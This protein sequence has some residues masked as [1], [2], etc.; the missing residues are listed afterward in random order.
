M[1]FPF[2]SPGVPSYITYAMVGAVIGHEV[3][4][5]FDDQGS[6]YDEYGNLH[7]W[8]DAKT[9]HKFYEK[10]QCFIKQYSAVKVKEAGVHLNGR[11]SVGENIADNAGVKTALIAYKSWLEK[12]YYR[13]VALPGFQNMTSIQM[14]FLAYANNWCSLIRPKYYLQIIMADVHAPSKYR[15][16]IPLQNRPEFAE[17]FHCPSGSPMNP[18]KKCSIW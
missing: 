17:A 2:M 13:E 8:W 9:A 6:L 18:T 11:L 4:H 10:T 15:A 7:N 3:S 14:F 16:I 5:A 1:Q 12:N